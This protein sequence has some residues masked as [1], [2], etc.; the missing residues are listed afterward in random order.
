[1]Y[2]QWLNLV[3]G[4]G[5][6]RKEKRRK[7]TE[8]WREKKKVLFSSEVPAGFDDVQEDDWDTED[9]GDDLGAPPPPFQRLRQLQL[10]VFGS[11][12]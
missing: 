11:V 10:N 5:E 3:V 12:L 9:S 4:E 8:M 2:R 1:M 6:A 7:A